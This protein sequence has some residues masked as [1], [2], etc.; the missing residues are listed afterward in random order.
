MGQKVTDQVAEMRSLPAGIDQR[1]PARHPDW[2]GP[3]DLALKVAELRELTK[4][5]VP[6]Q[7][8]LGAA[9]VYDDVRM[10]SLLERVDDDTVCFPTSLSAR[11][12]SAAHGVC[13]DLGL[14][15]WSEDVHDGGRRCVA[16][17]RRR[18]DPH[19]ARAASEVAALASS[20]LTRPHSAWPAPRN[21][22]RRVADDAWERFDGSTWAPCDRTGAW[23]HAAATASLVAAGPPRPTPVVRPPQ[24]PVEVVDSTDALQAMAA[25]L[26]R[27]KTPIAIDV[28]AH[29]EFSFEGFAC[30][31]QVSTRTKDY[32]VDC[33]ALRAE[34]GPALR[35]VFAD[36]AVRMVFHSC[37]GVDIP[38]LDRVRGPRLFPRHR[39]EI[40]P[41]LTRRRPRR[42]SG[43]AW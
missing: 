25:E 5:K 12:R 35:A 30:L 1:S 21:E 28:E 41:K 8:K 11:D 32:V 14:H 9:K 33:L 40:L 37:E 18:P 4:N 34:V 15:H 27:S 20:R 22:M 43:S 17:R 13:G 26:A 7:L 3:D 16:S 39:R 24:V 36:P 6:I 31:L 19:G 29:A 23:E 10:A 38:R 2:L 42:T